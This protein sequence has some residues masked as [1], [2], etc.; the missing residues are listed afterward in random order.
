MLHMKPF[1]RTLILAILLVTLCCLTPCAQAAPSAEIPYYSSGPFLFTIGYQGY[2]VMSSG[3]LFWNDSN[4]REMQRIVTRNDILAIAAPGEEQSNFVYYLTG[5][6]DGPQVLH[7][8]MGVGNVMFDHASLPEDMHVVHMEANMACLYALDEKGVLYQ[9]F[10]YSDGLADVYPLSD[11]DWTNTGVTA[12]ALH[13]KR[14]LVYQAERDTLTLLDFTDNSSNPTVT[15][16]VTVP[17]LRHM[18]FGGMDGDVPVVVVIVEENGRGRLSLI[19]MDDGACEDTG[20]SLPNDVSLLARDKTTLYVRGRKD[21]TL[22]TLPMRE[23]TGIKENPTLTIVNN[24]ASGSQFDRA[25]QMFHQKYPDVE[26]VE[27]SIRDGRIIATEMMAASDD[28]DVIAMQDNIM[29]ISAG[30]LL[31]TGAILDLNQFEGLVAIRE[32]Y[33]DIFGFVS[34]GDQWFGVPSG[35]VEGRTWR[36]NP[37]L[38]AELSWEPPTGRWTWAE[39]AELADRVRTYNQTAETPMYL[40]Q[41]SMNQCYFLYEY[42]ANHVNVLGGTADLNNETYIGMVRLWKELYDDGL[43]YE[44]NVWASMGKNVLLHSAPYVCLHDMARDLYV[45]PPTETESSLYPVCDFG[46]YVVNANTQHLEE[47]IYFLECYMSV[48]AESGRFYFNDG[49]WLKDISLYPD[50]TN[51]H[52]MHVQ[53]P[54]EENEAIWDYMLEH[55][56]PQLHLI[57]LTRQQ[58]F[59]LMPGVLDGSVTPEQFAQISQQLADMMLGE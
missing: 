24:M 32:N 3:T 10:A 59:T 21:T 54:S 45:L 27:R 5:S 8:V 42:Q 11:G 12:F 16:A 4:A 28:I 30:L 38:A 43:L 17:T 29:D 46:F 36:V 19:R 41:D 47:A 6:E 1:H 7:A 56:A 15:A 52:F 33:R 50:Y 2:W 44:D 48:E 18:Q 57:D 58:Q 35:L 25:V 55:S 14:M 13:G 39:F 40:L 53:M 37:D 20:I 22:Y 23:V 26:I 49:K 34:L 9:I 51:D 31:R